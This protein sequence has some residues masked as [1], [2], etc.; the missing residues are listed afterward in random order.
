MNLTKGGFVIGTH[1][2][3]SQLREFARAFR[4]L[5]AVRFDDVEGLT[6]P[7]R[8]R[9]KVVDGRPYFY[10][11]NCLPVP[12]TVSI[13]LADGQTV[14]DLVS[15]PPLRVGSSLSLSLE[16]APYELRS[17]R[18]DQ[19]QPVVLGGR[20]TVPQNFVQHLRRQ[21][22]TAARSPATPSG[23]VAPYLEKARECFAEGSYSRL[24]FLLQEAWGR[25]EQE[26]E[27]PE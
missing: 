24:Y 13:E 17:F 25:Q 21:L 23:D 20:V 10:V 9:Q 2:M 5:P 26:E 15:N 6:D 8:V 4:P 18:G 1:G 14:T 11:L 19:P 27:L 3:E 22:V 7:V 16:L 12:V